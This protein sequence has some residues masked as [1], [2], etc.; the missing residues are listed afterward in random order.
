MGHGTISRAGSIEDAVNIQYLGL[1]N[2]CEVVQDFGNAIVATEAKYMWTQSALL[3]TF[4]S[5]L[6][7]AY[8]GEDTIASRIH[9][10]IMCQGSERG[11]PRL[12]AFTALSQILPIS[13]AQNLFY[14]ATLRP[15]GHGKEAYLPR[16]G[17]VCAAIAYM[18]CM[19]LAPRAFSTTYLM[20]LILLLV[21]PFLFV[22]VRDPNPSPRK[23]GAGHN[24]AQQIIG[25]IS[26]ALTLI[27]IYKNDGFTIRSAA[28][29]L[30][31][32]PAVTALGLDSLL[33]I[34]SFLV[35]RATGQSFMEN[36]KAKPRVKAS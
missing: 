19:T 34:L 6:H 17:Y 32:A 33:S 2:S 25:A 4:A 10:L 11:I 36:S 3:T 26:A 28:S 5:C 7:M 23:T 13:F 16:T 31:E 12:W 27:Q 24:T 18:A 8:R 15:S 1:V 14:L 22:R 29:S 20:P 35:W 30:L 9:L 21:L